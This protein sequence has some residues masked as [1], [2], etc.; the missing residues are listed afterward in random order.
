MR[1]ALSR[2]LHSIPWNQPGAGAHVYRAALVYL[3]TQVEQGHGCP[4]TMT[5]SCVPT[6]RRQADLAEQWLPK[7]LATDYDPRDRP[8]EEKKAL[9]IG[10]ARTEKQRSA[11]LMAN[12]SIAR[13]PMHHGGG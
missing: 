8:K 2:G 6:L 10:M 5:F 11:E 9:T 13:T 4:V 3:Q 12:T 7:V 1:G